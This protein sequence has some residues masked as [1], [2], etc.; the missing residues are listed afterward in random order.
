[1]VM[2]PIESTGGDASFCEGVGACTGSVALAEMTVSRTR[3]TPEQT[4]EASPGE[5]QETGQRAQ[6]EAVIGRFPM[7]ANFLRTI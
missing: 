2:V 4:R 6:S 3:T 7:K 1:M 5:I